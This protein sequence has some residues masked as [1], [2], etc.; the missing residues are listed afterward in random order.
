MVRIVL[1]GIIAGFAFGFLAG[2]TL[3]GIMVLPIFKDEEE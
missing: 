2:A 3:I 1:L